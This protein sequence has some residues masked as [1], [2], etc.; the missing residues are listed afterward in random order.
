MWGCPSRCKTPS[1]SKPRQRPEKGH[2]AIEEE[3][4]EE[5]DEDDDDDDIEF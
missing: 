1:F 4:E 2:S 3:K 5:E